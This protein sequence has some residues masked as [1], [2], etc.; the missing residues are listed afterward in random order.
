VTQLRK[1]ML[2]GRKDGA[3]FAESFFWRFACAAPCCPAARN[4][5]KTW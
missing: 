3:M 4:S 5:M 1:R 2:E